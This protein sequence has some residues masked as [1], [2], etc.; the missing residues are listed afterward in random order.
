MVIIDDGV[1]GKN[2]KELRERGGE[3]ITRMGNNQLIII[4]KTRLPTT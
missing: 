3:E 1:K 2:K 4:M